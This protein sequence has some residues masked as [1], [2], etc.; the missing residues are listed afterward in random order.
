MAT[1]RL[2][3]THFTLQES[4]M[5]QIDNVNLSDLLESAALNLLTE[6]RKDA[7]S[8]IKQILVRQEAMAD[9]I[10]TKESELKK[11]REKMEKST[12]K[13]DRLRKGDWAVLAEIEREDA[14]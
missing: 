13:I 6:K 11:L 3:I 9:A 10:K 1:K 7:E 14:Q 2:A 4:T 8:R 5:K 12:A